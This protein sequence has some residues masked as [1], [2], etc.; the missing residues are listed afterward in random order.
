MAI[1]FILPVEWSCL[2][3]A[4][5]LVLI[6]RLF[7]TIACTKYNSNSSDYMDGENDEE[8]NLLVGVNAAET[9][10]TLEQNKKKLSKKRDKKCQ[11]AAEQERLFIEI[12]NKGDITALRDY[13][14]FFRNSNM[15]L[16]SKKKAKLETYLTCSS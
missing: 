6:L 13:F 2:K 16:E 8:N 11:I 4:A 14:N 5:S 3:S 15:P 9:P 12:Y 1:R 10:Q 7:C